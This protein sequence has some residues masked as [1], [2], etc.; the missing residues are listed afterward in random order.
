MPTSVDVILYWQT[1]W[2][3]TRKYLSEAI[4]QGLEF[5]LICAS[6]EDSPGRTQIAALKRED[7]FW[8]FLLDPAQELPDLPKSDDWEIFNTLAKHCV[9]IY[10]LPR[11]TTRLRE[12]LQS[13]LEIPVAR[14]HALLR[15][16]REIGLVGRAEAFRASL[17][18][19]AR[20]A[21]Y[22]VPVLIE[23]ETGTGK[24]LFARAL[25][26]LGA[27][28]DK[29]FMPINCGALPDDLLESELF[30]HAR[31]AFTGAHAEARGLVAQAEGGTLFLDEVHTLSPKGQ[32]TL[33]RFLQDQVFRPVGGEKLRR[34]DIRIVAATNSKL[35]NAVAEGSF[36]EDLFYRLEVA[37]IALPALCERR[38]DIPLLVEHSVAR[39]CRRFRTGPR[40]FDEASMAWFCAQPWCG[41]VRELENQVCR[42][43][44]L[45]DGTEIRA[46]PGHAAVAGDTPPKARYDVS[47][48]EARARVVSDFEA[49]YL[50]AM[51][52]HTRGNVTKAARQ[53]GNDR[54]V[55]GRLMRKH[56]IDR[57]EFL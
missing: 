50:R 19:M 17:R 16:C 31:G 42:A 18:M 1:D 47:F 12:H 57:C 6:P 22:D 44:L 8:S 39:L 27:R 35:K 21:P 49:E 37:A 54:R 13:R 33:L 4:P 30:G 9:E 29:P 38:E 56:G 28:R 3:E 20:L 48:K 26:Y 11:D 41:N 45:S 2:E 52:A 24:E 5:S 34:A 46:G 43:F 40:H 14:D 25:H 53:A 10:S 51:L 23:G 15:A 36:R 32:V 7:G 55:F